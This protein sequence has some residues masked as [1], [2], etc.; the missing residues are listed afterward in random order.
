MDYELNEEQK[1]IKNAAKE[2]AE[3]EFKPEIAR[4]ADQ[5]HQF[6]KDLY[7]K[8]AKLGFIGCYYDEKYGGQGLG[9]LE[10]RF[11]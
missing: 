11:G 2:F 4:E 6:P 1:F 7:K 10:K 8:A 5:K 9:L 3:G